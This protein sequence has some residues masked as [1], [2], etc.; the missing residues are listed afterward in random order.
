MLCLIGKSREAVLCWGL[1][2]WLAISGSVSAQPAPA[3]QAAALTAKLKELQAAVETLRAQDPNPYLLADVEVYAK[4]VDWALRHNEFYSPKLVAAALVQLDRGLARAK[5]LTDGKATWDQQPGSLV[6]GYYSAIEGSV[7]PYVVK[8]PPSFAG[9]EKERWPLH[10]HLH[11][12]G[13][14]LNEINF[15]AQHDEHSVPAEQTWIQLDVFGRT[16]NGYRWAGETD[17]LEA[18][19]A[20]KKRYRIDPK[21]VVLR[22]FSMGGAGSWHLGLHYPSLWCSVGPGAGFVDFYK[23]QKVTEKLPEYQD[24]T[25]KIY[26]AVDYALNAANVPVVTYG[27]ELDPQ[28]AASTEMVAAAK[29]LDVQIEQLIGPQ[30]GHKFDPESLAKYMAFHLAA[31]EKGRPTFPG[32]K[33]FRFVTYTPRYNTIEGLQIEELL[34]PYQQTLVEGK[35]D[36]DN[37]MH[38]TTKNVAVLKIARDVAD[39]VSIDGS[40]HN[41]TSAAEGLLPEVYFRS[42]GSGWDV[43]GYDSSL[44]FNK[45][46]DRRKRKGLQGPIDDAFMEPFVCVR[47]TGTPWSEAH[48][49]WAK[50]TLDR[51]EQEFDQF[52]RGKIVIVDDTAVTPEMIRDKH[53]ILFGDPG[54]NKLIGQLH[55]QLPV[56]WTEATVTVNGQEHAA[57]EHAAVLI[58][59]NPMNLRRYVVLNS[60]HTFHATEFKA[61]NAQLY[62]RLGDIAVVKFQEAPAGGYQ[63]QTVWGG[64]FNNSWRLPQLPGSAE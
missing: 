23:Y 52:L 19:N 29:A 53:L 44:T 16:N 56:K 31:Q 21:R 24:Q 63:E 61:S 11:G 25:L 58:Y 39:N 10:I 12:R 34:F 20:V 30:T 46:L 18:F 15:I 40:L 49:A 4:G 27:G 41:L 37:V 8:L 7:Q 59:P 3:E 26:D 50:W 5:I 13:D 60:G 6:R 42:G 48:A 14:Q 33:E 22:G 54:S 45:N 64:I 32:L 55:K 9:R 62:P 38:I 2:A 36:T 51:F 35:L 57:N 28:L 47:P 1:L 43:M 17:V